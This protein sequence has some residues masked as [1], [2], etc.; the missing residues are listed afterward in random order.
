MTA[1]SMHN[2]SE[3]L[4]MRRIL[5]DDAYFVVTWVF[6]GTPMLVAGQ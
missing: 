2:P 4:S 5:S 6:A 1:A 3:R